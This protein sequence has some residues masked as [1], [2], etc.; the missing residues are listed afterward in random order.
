M[1][2]VVFLMMMFHPFVLLPSKFS[3]RPS[4][5]S[6]S[7]PSN[8]SNV[9][10]IDGYAIEIDPHLASVIQH[11]DG[12]VSVVLIRHEKEPTEQA[13]VNDIEEPVTAA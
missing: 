6:N 5:R 11:P 9:V 1:V 2:V 3:F 12:S 4:L 7:D 10:V 13:R 8:D